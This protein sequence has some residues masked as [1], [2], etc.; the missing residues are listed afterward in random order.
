MR[1]FVNKSCN[2]VSS[3][4]LGKRVAVIVGAITL[5]STAH[6]FIIGTGTITGTAVVNQGGILSL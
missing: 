6:A 2:A 3:L 1:N 4:F 5:V